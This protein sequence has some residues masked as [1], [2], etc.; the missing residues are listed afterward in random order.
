MWY[1]IDRFFEIV[2]VLVLGHG[3]ISNHWSC[4][5]IMTTDFFS[6]LRWNSTHVFWKTLGGVEGHLERYGELG[7]PKMHV[8]KIH[9]NA[10][11]TSHN[12]SLVA[13]RLRCILLDWSTNCTTCESW[14]LASMWP[15]TWC[16]VMELDCPIS[17]IHHISL[18]KTWTN[19]KLLTLFSTHCLSQQVVLCQVTNEETLWKLAGLISIGI[20]KRGHVKCIW[21]VKDEGP[22]RTCHR[23]ALSDRHG[24]HTLAPNPTQQ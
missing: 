1:Y 7:N 21:N 9:R 19:W 12:W 17:Y 15:F 4:M 5:R 22:N 11:T 20:G 13:S 23:Q 10:D 3:V 2:V 18:V 8:Y 14:E 24:P 16:D 6:V